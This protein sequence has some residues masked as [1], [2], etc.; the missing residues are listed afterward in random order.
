MPKL[1]DVQEMIWKYARFDADYITAKH[2]EQLEHLNRVH[3]NGRVYL[4]SE[5]KDVF[6]VGCGGTSSLHA[7]GF[8]SWGT[9][10]TQTRPIESGALKPD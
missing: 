5:P 1:E 6:V 8:H 9:C 2:R 7:A 10:L 4:A 3:K